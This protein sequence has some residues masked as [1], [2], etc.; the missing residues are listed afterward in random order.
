MP[1]LRTDRS[2]GF[3]TL[4]EVPK[5]SDAVMRDDSR[6][7]SHCGLGQHLAAVDHLSKHLAAV[8]LYLISLE[9]TLCGNDSSASGWGRCSD[10]GHS[11]LQVLQGHYSQLLK[12]AVG[13][14]QELEA[15]V[16]RHRKVLLIHLHIGWTSALNLEQFPCAI[17]RS[18]YLV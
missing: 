12:N 3:R 15:K 11:S 9:L 16:H 18:L 14:R 8:E 13:S 7:R 4:V 2:F 10:F 6:D 5:K 1:M 17:C